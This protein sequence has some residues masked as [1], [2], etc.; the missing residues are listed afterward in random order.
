MCSAKPYWE[1]VLE[2][3]CKLPRLISHRY[4]QASIAISSEGT[5]TGRRSQ[6]TAIV[7]KLARRIANR[8]I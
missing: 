1:V 7:L 2:E 3:S 4:D 5:G 8:E 6:M